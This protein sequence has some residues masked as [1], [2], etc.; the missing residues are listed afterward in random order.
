MPKDIKAGY[1]VDIDKLVFTPNHKP[2]LKKLLGTDYNPH[3]RYKR[4]GER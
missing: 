4:S 2:V 3:R 1:P